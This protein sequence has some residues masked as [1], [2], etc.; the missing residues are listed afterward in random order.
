M[1]DLE[2]VKRESNGRW[3]GIYHQLGIDVGIGKHKPC[4]HCGGKDRFRFSDLSGNGEYYCNQCSYGD[5]FDLVM[6]IF[7]CTFIESV[8]KVA[9]IL[10][11]VEDDFKVEKP[12]KDP[13]Y[14][15]NKLWSASRMSVVGDPVDLYLKERGIEFLPANI[16]TCYSC[17]ESDT[18]RNYMAMVA[19]VMNKQ[20]KGVS[21]HR[22]YLDGTGK[23][24]IESPKKLMPPTESLKGC[25]IQLMYPAY[26][27]DG[28]GVAEGIETAL[29]ATLLF[30]TAT[31]AVI[32]TA[33]MES[34][35]PPQ[36]YNKIIIYGD[37]DTNYSG[38]KAA[39]SLAK[40]L[41]DK[42]FLAEVRIPPEVGDWND[43][44][45]KKDRK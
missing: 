2:R 33:L 15:L 44:L 8:Q 23:A 7:G 28:I 14:A 37:N 30:G 19:K 22:T 32:S 25:A 40:K 21:I 20:G 4:P 1:I 24:K 27:E 26:D 16:R 39:Y 36:K 10:G 17:Y 9:N 45:L 5:G 11:V 12:K 35:E 41:N 31:W 18:K 3:A 34:F 38:Q 43:V 29:S 42:G 13:A 6:K